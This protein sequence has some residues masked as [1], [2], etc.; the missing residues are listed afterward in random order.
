MND[1][2]PEPLIPSRA[3][4][5]RQMLDRGVPPEKIAQ[6]LNCRLSYVYMVRWRTEHP[7]TATNWQKHF[8][9]DNDRG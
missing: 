5:I 7:V 2:L 6:R 8:Q 1:D 9:S 4:Q 3:E